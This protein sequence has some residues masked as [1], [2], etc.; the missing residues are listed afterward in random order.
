MDQK[1]KCFG[2]SLENSGFESGMFCSLDFE[3]IFNFANTEITNSWYGNRLGRKI[4]WSYRNN[5][6]QTKLF[7]T[8]FWMVKTKRKRCASW[9][10]FSQGVTCISACHKTFFSFMKAQFNILL[11]ITAY[12]SSFVL[13]F[14]IITTSGVCLK[15]CVLLFVNFVGLLVIKVDNIITFS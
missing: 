7:Q 4:L 9:F 2:I 10:V 3:R 15:Y 8:M 12:W 14:V 13:K 6:T 5:L 1:E 11:T